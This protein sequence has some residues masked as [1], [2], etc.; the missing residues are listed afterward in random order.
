MVT[1]CFLISIYAAC[2]ILFF[3]VGWVR[4][5]LNKSGRSPNKAKRKLRYWLIN[6]DDIQK[7][8]RVSPE[9]GLPEG[10]AFIIPCDKLQSPDS[11]EN[12]HMRFI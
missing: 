11:I 8:F 3:L 4:F 12:H 1:V 7:L 5:F 9:P 2:N 10:E 6:I